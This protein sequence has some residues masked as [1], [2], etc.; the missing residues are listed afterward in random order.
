[1]IAENTGT[2]GGPEKKNSESSRGWGD[3]FQGNFV[4]KG[5]SEKFPYGITER[6]AL[7]A[8]EFRPRVLRQ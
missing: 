3:L 6:L 7:V 5:L 1:M 4:R 2:A 8:C